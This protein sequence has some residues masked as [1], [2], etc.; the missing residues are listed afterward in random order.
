MQKK[1][2]KNYNLNYTKITLIGPY[3]LSLYEIFQMNYPF[4]C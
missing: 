1:T 3:L 2:K 4:K